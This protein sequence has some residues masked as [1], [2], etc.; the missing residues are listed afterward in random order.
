MHGHH[1]CVAW[2]PSEV[3]N[4]PLRQLDQ[5]RGRGGAELASLAST[6]V[7]N[8]IVHELTLHTNGVG[9]RG[10]EPAFTLQFREILQTELHLFQFQILCNLCPTNYVHAAS[11]HEFAHACS[12]RS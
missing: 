5:W 1:C 10:S 2:Q 4:S 8:R 7:K 9:G 6:L 12:F 11:N 3:K